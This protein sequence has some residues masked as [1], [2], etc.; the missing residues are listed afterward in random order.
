MHTW[1]VSIPAATVERGYPALG[2]FVGLRVVRRDGHG[3]WNGRVEKLRLVGT[4]G[5]VALSGD[6]MRLRYGLRSSWFRVMP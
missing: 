2:R 1:T 4:R 5:S 3:D 6:D